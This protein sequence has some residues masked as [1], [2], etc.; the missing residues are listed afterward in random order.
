MRV[1]SKMF[2]RHLFF[3]SLVITPALQVAHA[4]TIEFSEDELATE[5]VLPVFDKTVVVRERAVKTT[6]R[7]E[8]GVGGGLN[9]AEPLYSQTVFDVMGV[10]SFDEVNGMNIFATFLSSQ[11]STAGS[12]LAAGQGLQ[13]G[14]SNP[15]FDAS[16]APTV[17]NMTFAN[18]QFTAYYGKISIAK[19]LTMNLSLYG[20]AGLGMVKW[21]DVAKVGVDVGFGQKLYFNEHNAI[22]F[23]MFLAMYQGPDP[24]NPTGSNTMTTG[25][26]TLPSSAFSTTT[27]I[28]PFMTL[29]YVYLF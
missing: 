13:P 15:N 10:Y 24:T 22:R 19:E 21:T 28:R 27:Y 25:G 17:Q 18:Y 1:S 5:S 12:E 8:I 16:L 6:G 7:I 23:D 2:L 9:L 26:P 3:Y 4:E 20:M 14:S 11:L 29:G